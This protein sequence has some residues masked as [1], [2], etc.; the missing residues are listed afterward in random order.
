MN[1]DYYP[2]LYSASPDGKG[3]LTYV[4]AL[5]ADSLD[6][7]LVQYVQPIT[8]DLN[9][10]GASDLIVAVSGGIA[11][12]YS[13]HDGTFAQPTALNLGVQ[14]GCSISYVDAGDVNGDGYPDMVI[15]YPGD[16]YCYAGSTVPSGYFVLLNNHDG[17]FTP[18]LYASRNLSVP[19]QTDRPERRRQAGPGNSR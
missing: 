5:S 9:G 3:G 1:A 4:K 11:V 17:S 15:A 19:A 8:A 18:S 14:L 16:S 2:D 10:D 13:N 6:A 7:A 12:S